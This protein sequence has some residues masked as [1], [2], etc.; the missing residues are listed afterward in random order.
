M[1]NLEQDIAGR[2]PCEEYIIC[3][4]YGVE[5]RSLKPVMSQTHTEMNENQR[6]PEGLI[7]QNKSIK[8][9]KR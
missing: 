9:L 6:R 2:E 7:S 8:P 3:T 4:I 1:I 5:E